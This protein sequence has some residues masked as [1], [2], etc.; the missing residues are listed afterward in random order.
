[1]TRGAVD[2]E[3]EGGNAEV[4]TDK[5]GAV[6]EPRFVRHFTIRMYCFLD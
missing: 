6:E 3:R 5:E 2:E 1:M 4:A